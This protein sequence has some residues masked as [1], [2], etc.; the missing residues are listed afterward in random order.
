MA[1]DRTTSRTGARATSTRRPYESPLRSKRAKETRAALIR[2]AT[3]LFTANGWTNTG[4]RDVAR[5]AGVAVETLYKHFSSKRKLLDAVVDQAAAGDADPIPVAGRPEFL[6][7]GEG[8]RA[9]RI[10][11]AAAVAAAINDRTGRF[12]KLIREAAAAE[13]EIA[14]VLRETRERQRSDVATGLEL[15]LGRKPTVHERDGA[16]AIVSPE[17]YLLLTE[18]SGWSLDEY[19]R[20][21]SAT[22]DLLLPSS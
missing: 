21:L 8:R 13:P 6:A 9:G 15:V 11:A 17:L 7:M 3:E 4:M 2:A 22:L 14:E 1:A 20:W 10:A 5:E 12:A 16:W 19:E 18:D